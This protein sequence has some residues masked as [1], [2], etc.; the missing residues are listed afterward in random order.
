MIL[1]TFLLGFNSVELL[2]N[3]LCVKATYDKAIFH[4][5]PQDTSNAPASTEIQRSGHPEEQYHHR[6]FGP[7][8]HQPLLGYA[9]RLRLDSNKRNTHKEGIKEGLRQRPPPKPTLP[10]LSPT[11]TASSSSSVALDRLRTPPLLGTPVLVVSVLTRPASDPRRLLSVLSSSR[12]RLR[13]ASF[14]LLA[15]SSSDR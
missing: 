2:P 14:S 8:F 13:S 12:M 9:V 7:E 10:A 15:T 3:L 11:P 4:H 6:K 5:Q 1:F